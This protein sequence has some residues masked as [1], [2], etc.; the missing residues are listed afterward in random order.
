MCNL[1]KNEGRKWVCS[2]QA[3]AKWFLGLTLARNPKLASERKPDI[4]TDTSLSNDY[5]F[6]HVD[7]K[8][9]VNQYTSDNAR[10]IE[11]K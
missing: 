4:Q 5:R 7:V 11:D 10:L 8:I 2:P 1:E 6:K 9:E 3:R